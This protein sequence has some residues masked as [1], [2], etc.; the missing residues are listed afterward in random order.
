MKRENE[1]KI[2]ILEIQKRKIQ[3][4]IE[5][6]LDQQSQIDKKIDRIRDF[7]TNRQNP[8]QLKI[9]NP[10]SISSMSSF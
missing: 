4:K 5:L 9:Q 1:L 6:L 3:E 10:A 8:D 7:S 2:E